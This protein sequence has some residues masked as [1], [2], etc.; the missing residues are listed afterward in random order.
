FTDPSPT[1]IYPLS[2]H[3]ALPISDRLDYRA[4]TEGIADYG[5]RGSERH[6]A[7]GSG[8]REGVAVL[9]DRDL[10]W[11]WLR[12]AVYEITTGMRSGQRSE[13]H[14]SELQSPCNLVCRLLL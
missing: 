13:E 8:R 14:T 7:R 11:N 2:L 12:G 10:K 3:D 9:R 4:I 6:E 5:P 1:A